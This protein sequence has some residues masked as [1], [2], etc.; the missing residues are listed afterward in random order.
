[1]ACRKYKGQDS[2]LWKMLY[3]RAGGDEYVADAMYNNLFLSKDFIDKYGDWVNGESKIAVNDIGEPLIVWDYDGEANE[4]AATGNKGS[5][6]SLAVI[7]TDSHVSLTPEQIDIAMY[8]EGKAEIVIPFQYKIDKSSKALKQL[9]LAEQQYYNRQLIGKPIEQKKA[10]EAILNAQAKIKQGQNGYKVDGVAKELTRVSDYK[11][12]LKGKKGEDD[13]YVTNKETTVDSSLQWGNIVDTVLQGIVNGKS[14]SD[15]KSV[16]PTGQYSISDNAL[17]KVYDGLKYLVDSEIARGNIVLSQMSL[18][19]TDKMVAGTTDIIIVQ[20]DGSIKIWDLKTSK[21]PF[22]RDYTKMYNGK[23]YTNNYTKPFM[24]KGKPRASRKDMHEAQLSLYKGL[25][26]SMGFIPDGSNNELMIIPVWLNDITETEIRGVEMQSPINID[27]SRK[28][29]ELVDNQVIDENTD[30][31]ISLFNKVLKAL[32]TKVYQ[33]QKEGKKTEYLEGILANISHLDYAKGIEDFINITFVDVL[34]SDNFKGWLAIMRDEIERVR[35]GKFKQGHLLTIMHRLQR[36]KDIADLYNPKNNSLISEM[37]EYLD[38]EGIE[39]EDGS[40]ID[41]ARKIL[42]AVNEMQTKF[43][44]IMPTLLS[45]ILAQEIGSDITSGISNDIKILED[46][47]KQAEKEGK[48][49]AFIERNFKSKIEDL[50]S[51][52]GMDDKGN[53]NVAKQIE[54]EIRTG[55]YKDISAFDMW[56]V[57]TISQN[58]LIL[59]SFAKTVKTRFEEYRQQLR[60]FQFE[61]KAAFDDFAKGGKSGNA[62]EFN[63]GLYEEVER[64][65]GR[66]DDGN[67]IFVKRMAFVSPIDFGK[68]ERAK[69]QRQREVASLSQQQAEEQMKKWYEVNRSNRPKD[70]ISV[71]GVVIME[72]YDTVVK[73]KAD[74]IAQ[75]I[76][77]KNKAKDELDK[78]ITSIG[79]KIALTIPNMSIYSNQAYNDMIKNDRLSRYYSFL[80]KTYFKAQDRMPPRSEYNKFILP[81]ISK[82]SN[83]RLRE[84]GIFDYMKYKVKDTFVILVEDNESYGDAVGTNFKAIPMLY[85]QDMNSSDVSLDLIASVLR[86]E[87]ASLRYEAQSSLSPISDSLLSLVSNT[88]PSVETSTGVKVLDKAAAAL[89]LKGHQHYLKKHNSNNVAALLEQFIDVNIYG[90]Y[91]KPYELFNAFGKTFDMGKISNTIM[92]FAARTNLTFNPLGSVANALQANMMVRMEAYSKEYFDVKHWRGALK[93]YGK[94]VFNADFVRDMQQG[95]HLSKIGQLIDVF[96]AIQGDFKD[97]YG[98]TMSHTAAKKA[99]SWNTAFFLQHAGEHQVQVSTM[100]ALLKSTMVKDKSGKEISLYDAYETNPTSKKIQL[101]EGVDVS[102]LGNMVGIVPRQIQDRLHAINKRLHGVYNKFDRPMIERHWYGRLLTFYRKFLV[103]G[104]KARWRGLGVDYELGKT[105]EGTYQSFFRLLRTDFRKLAKS[106]VPWRKDKVE[107]LTDFEY[108]NARRA[109]FEFG[110]IAITGALVMIMKGINEGATD[111]RDKYA[112]LLY[113][114]MRLNSELGFYGGIGDPQSAGLPNIYE[115]YRTFKTPTVAY[116]TVDKAFKVLYQSFSPFEQYDRDT[117]LADKGDYK[118]PVSI[119][120]LF[121]IN[122]FNADPEEAVKVITMATGGK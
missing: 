99:M 85:G 116:Y 66:D 80:I 75:H 111:E 12:G 49:K 18:Y 93:E 28:I 11:E 37:I 35:K 120:K 65:E 94:S 2:K 13:Y 83:D 62:A 59:A 121:G 45:N 84:N 57:P 30:D 21:D 36:Y 104:F 105:V 74:E 5:F 48:S 7:R 98:R 78:W 24:K 61:A 81:S 27:G 16:L 56:L 101:K 89:G 33:M 108:H 26:Q 51:K 23:E 102:S 9:S 41:K 29:A 70:D 97:N 54:L 53:V 119:M 68:Y 77:D 47:M 6:Y 73:R 34:G 107:G 71:H 91:E 122:G 79:G 72:G 60:D 95:M 17:T 43:N 110:V 32:K 15:I 86:F 88:S 87:E 8:S 64:M 63:K 40:P 10:A 19:N 109:M 20:R 4:Y 39:S 96:D 25:A 58:N 114:T 117:A 106:I 82:S 76:K 31:K 46:R 38:K 22:D 90:R 115:M 113:W 44:D 69:A 55:G 14:I 42:V 1:M 100:I 52:I 92:S 67:P 118:L 50:K 112:Y 103:S 3:D